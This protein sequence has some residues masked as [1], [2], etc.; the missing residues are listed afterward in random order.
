[1]YHLVPKAPPNRE[2]WEDQG[3]CNTWVSICVH[4]PHNRMTSCQIWLSGKLDKFPFYPLGNR[5]KLW[6]N[7]HY[8]GGEFDIWY[9]SIHPP[10]RILQKIILLREQ[11]INR[12]SCTSVVKNSWSCPVSICY[13]GGASGA[14]RWSQFWLVSIAWEESPRNKELCTHL[15]RTKGRCV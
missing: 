9:L 15:T 11:R 2:Y 12:D 5:L 7:L 14:K 3:D 6:A 8:G 4:D 13:F 1:M 10:D